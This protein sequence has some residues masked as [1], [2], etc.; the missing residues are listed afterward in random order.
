MTSRNRLDGEAKE[1]DRWRDTDSDNSELS[2]DFGSDD[3]KGGAGFDGLQNRRTTSPVTVWNSYSSWCRHAYKIRTRL[4]AYRSEVRAL[5]KELSSIRDIAR[6]TPVKREN[7]SNLAA[8]IATARGKSEA[9][10]QLSLPL[11]PRVDKIICAKLRQADAP[12]IPKPSIIQQH[13]P[14]LYGPIG[15]GL[16]VGVSLLVSRLNLAMQSMLL[17]TFGKGSLLTPA[18]VGIGALAGLF[19][20][21]YHWWSFHRWITPQSSSTSGELLGL[22]VDLG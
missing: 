22:R 6:N 14:R 8:D 10:P 3:S 17:E 11:S 4:R 16:V 18:A 5:Q 21:G 2:S 19:V 13:L 1:L 9:N 12:S 7:T 20:A 15:S